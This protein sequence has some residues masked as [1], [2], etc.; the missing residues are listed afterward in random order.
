MNAVNNAEHRS[1]RSV[2]NHFDLTFVMNTF[3]KADFEK[4]P[5]RYQTDKASDWQGILRD[6]Q[7]HV[8]QH[9]GHHRHLPGHHAAV[10]IE[11]SHCIDST[12][13]W[14]CI[15]VHTI[16]ILWPLGSRSNNT[17]NKLKCFVDLSFVFLY[18]EIHHSTT[19]SCP[20]PPRQRQAIGI[21]RA[22]WSPT[23]RLSLQHGDITVACLSRGGKYRHTFS[24]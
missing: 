2:T 17:L 8:D 11:F 24:D 12:Y 14:H 18:L 3:W 6:K 16:P 22:P 4:S 7:K 13:I 23:G 20:F 9:V 5:G 15:Y 10:K 1:C 19:V 21:W